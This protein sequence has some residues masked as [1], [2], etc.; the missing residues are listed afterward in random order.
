[1]T[2]PSINSRRKQVLVDFLREVWD[3]GDTDACERF[4]APSYTI[5][6]DLGDP[7]AGQ[8]LDLAGYQARL[9]NSRALFPDQCFDVAGL[10][11]DG[12]VVV[13]TWSWRATHRGDVPGFPATGERITMSGMTVCSFDGDGMKR[14]ASEQLRVRWSVSGQRISGLLS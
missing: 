5:H 12:D 4:L 8:T 1:M 11:E 3:E 10:F 13:A 9:R 14:G 7:W 6:H 2:P